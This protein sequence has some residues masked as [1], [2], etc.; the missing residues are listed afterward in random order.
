MKRVGSKKKIILPII[1]VLTGALLT[2]SLVVYNN[3]TSVSADATFDGVTNIVKNKN[4]TGSTFNILELVPQKNMGTIGY[5][6]SGQEPDDISDSALSAIVRYGAIGTDDRVKYISALKNKLAFITSEQNDDSKPLYYENYEESYVQGDESWTELTLAGDEVI[7][8]NTQGYSMQNVGSGNGDYD[9]VKYVPVGS[10]EAS[11]SG[12]MCNQNVDYYVYLDKDNTNT[13]G[14]YNIE[15]K[16]VTL[17]AGQTNS[18]YFGVQGENGAYVNKAYKLVKFTD[19]NNN[20]VDKYVYVPYDEIVNDESYYEVGDDSVVFCADGSGKYGAVLDEKEPYVS[21]DKNSDASVQ[22]I[23]NFV[24]IESSDTYSYV[25]ENKGTYTLKSDKNAKLDKKV[26]TNKIYYKGGIKSNDWF[27]NKVL[28]EDKNVKIRVRTVTPEELNNMT[29]N[30]IQNM[31]LLYLSETSFD[32]KN[33]AVFDANHDVSTEKA[34]IILKRALF[35]NPR[36][37]IA[38]DG[39]IIDRTSDTN[40]IYSGCNVEKVSKLIASDSDD[41][42]NQSSYEGEVISISKFQWY[43]LNDKIKK[44]YNY[45]NGYVKEN[46]YVVPYKENQKKRGL[47]YKFTNSLTTCAKADENSGCREVAKYINTQNSIKQSNGEKTYSE[48]ISMAT[49][50]SYIL[51]I[52]NSI[53]NKLDKLNVL[54]VDPSAINYYNSQEDVLKKKT[55]QKWLSSAYPGDDNVNIKTVTCA[56]F[57]GMVGDLSQYDLI[58][59][60]LNISQYNKKETWIS[61]QKITETQ[62]NDSNMNGLIYSNIGDIVVINPKN[63]H[64]GLLNSDYINGT[65]LNTKLATRGNDGIYSSEENTYRSS[66]NDITDDRIKALNKYLD[67][68]NPI[69]FQYGFFNNDAASTVN[70]KYIDVNSKMYKFLDSVRT[71]GNAFAVDSGNN[72][73]GLYDYI[74]LERPSINLAEQ[75]K[76]EGKKYIDLKTNKITLDF[77]VDAKGDNV[78]EN[79]SYVVKFFID[80]NVDGK[81]AV[82]EQIDTNQVKLFKNEDGKKESVAASLD[83]NNKSN[84]FVEAGKSYTLEYELPSNYVGLISWKLLTCMTNNENRY[85]YKVGYCHVAAT[86]ETKVKLN[87]LQIMPYDATDEGNMEKALNKDTTYLSNLNAFINEQSDYIITIHSVKLDDLLKICDAGNLKSYNLIILGFDAKYS[88]AANNVSEKNKEKRALNFIKEYIENGYPVVITHGTTSYYNVDD[89]NNSNEWGYEF[90]KTL[91][92]IVGMDRYGV[93]KN[94]TLK[95]GIQ[96]AQSSNDFSNVIEQADK[97]K[98][99]IPYVPVSSALEKGIS[100][101]IAKQ[102]QGFTYG[103]LN[104]FQERYNGHGDLALYDGLTSNIENI[105][106]QGAEI[107]EGQ[108][109]MYPFN[110]ESLSNNSEGRLQVT[111]TSFPYYQL[112]LNEDDDNDGETDLVV[113]YTLNNMKN[114]QCLYSKS[115]GDVRNN[116]YLYTKGNITYIGAGDISVRYQIDSDL[117]LFI[118]TVIASYEAAPHEPKL[119]LKESYDR[120]SAD[121]SSLYVTI[122]NAINQENNLDGNIDEETQDVYFTITDTNSLRY[123]IKDETKEHAKFYIECLPGEKPDKVIGK[124][125]AEINLKQVN[126]EIYEVNSDGTDGSKISPTDGGNVRDYFDNDKTYKIKVP[127]NILTSGKN[128]VKVYVYAYSDIVKNRRGK[129]IQMTSPE[130]GKTFDV[131]R[132]GLADLD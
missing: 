9:L 94:K 56:Q 20:Q 26:S 122:D 46:L 125:G 132:L 101:T 89:S 97:D 6:V 65:S 12:K 31:D 80:S 114:V 92:D 14:Y 35:A 110:I 64:S 7:S 15:F 4:D 87:I 109:T 128:S 2:T 37:P 55:L 70:D 18:D 5:L 66:G 81:Y 73:S 124:S 45:P 54:E 96:I 50:I 8:A 90:N 3:L 11:D 44:F 21:A 28:G 98:T 93:T 19:K 10:G 32:G 82:G 63:G 33:S 88:L 102:S 68:N 25:G 24:Q 129:K 38:I 78:N 95:N 127:M 126:W 108:I 41:K 13:K 71:R 42:M 74:S 22:S 77:S 86:A 104:K 53:T 61:G 100:T 123:Q 107:N 59:F 17:P 52:G 29:D 79:T 117:K 103:D 106:D 51:T 49:N 69:V 76:A 16:Q 116:Y 111:K 119:E 43:R 48:N 120:N 84:Y 30:D 131:R 112:N 99:D 27:R 62:Y 83:S 113:W 23:Y 72:V 47:I 1:L 34:D 39:S 115:E 67:G 85:D 40:V 130:T 91:R 57:I 105:T 58:Y 75:K 60:G 118:N 36:C 121:V